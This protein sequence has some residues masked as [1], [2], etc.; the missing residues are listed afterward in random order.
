MR[1]TRA[2]PLT[3]TLLAAAIGRPAPA[4][5][6]GRL[7]LEVLVDGATLPEY[8][9]RGTTYVEA[10]RHREYALRLTN[11]EPVRVAVALAVDGRNTID[12]RHTS[13]RSARKWILEPYQSIVLDG[14]QTSD[15]Q[16]NRFVFTSERS[17]YAKWLGDVSQCGVIE[18]V[19]FRE[20]PAPPPVAVATP[21]P[22][23]W[24]ELWP[25]GVREQRA[26]QE[27]PRAAQQAQAPPT[28]GSASGGAA[29]GAKAEQRADALAERDEA[30][31]AAATGFGRELR[32]EVVRVAF[33][34][35]DGPSASVRMRYEYRDELVRLGVLPAPQPE[36]IARREAARGFT[37]GGWCPVP[38]AR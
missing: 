34:H 3:L 26:G 13:A 5:G 18:A 29:P 22:P 23:W 24:R 15:R 9:A 37:D 33:E 19:A 32:H 11:L 2:L 7:R 28:L 31:D 10:R 27:A 20:R 6:D 4:A 35:E 21:Q 1:L 38:P 36:P 8:F 16:A 25:S 30:G 14:W 12:A 17:S